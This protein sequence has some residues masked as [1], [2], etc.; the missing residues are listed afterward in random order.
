MEAGFGM[1]FPGLFIA[2][3]N[4]PLGGTLVIT[5]SILAVAALNPAFIGNSRNNCAPYG[6]AIAVVE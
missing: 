1:L 6:K 5:G 4:E 3:D 2:P